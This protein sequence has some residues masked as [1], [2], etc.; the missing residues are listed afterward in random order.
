MPESTFGFPDQLS[1]PPLHPDQLSIDTPEQVAL[2][3]PLAGVGSRFLA[4]L[5]DSVLQFV[6]YALMIL[7]IV[8]LAGSAPQTR[9]D[10]L[11]HTAE[12]WFIAGYIVFNFLLFWGYFSLFEAFWHGQTPGKRLVRIRVLKDSGRSITLFEA[13]SR[14]LL[15]VV[16]ALPG[17]YL[18][19]VAFIA[20]TRENK[21]L[22]DLVAGTIVVHERAGDQPLMPQQQSRL[23]QLAP[24]PSFTPVA[25][26]PPRFASDADQLPADAIARL[27]P[28]DLQA[29]ETFFARALD[30]S[31]E[32]RELLAARVAAAFA[33]KMGVSLPEGQSPERML[34]QVAYR[35]RAGGR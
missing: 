12:K 28:Q 18:L 29:V 2:R 23:Y 26:P 14:N 13:L 15:R 24:A 9:P 32:R 11:S 33:A 3:F 25:A 35:M 4:L 5:A 17:F 16:D 27:T 31:V 7:G 34:E 21:R 30:L 19:G 10:T 20:M 6:V 1:S 22:G 8:L